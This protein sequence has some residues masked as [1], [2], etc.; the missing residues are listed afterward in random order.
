MSEKYNIK[1]TENKWRKKW[2]DAKAFDVCEDS[3]KPKYYVLAM[4]PYPSG[5]IH[6]GHVRNYTLSD[7]VARYKKSRGFNVLNPMGWDALGLPAENAAMERNVHPSDWTYSNIAQMKAQLLSM[8]LAID[9][10]REVATC[11]PE[12]YKHEQKM[13]IEFFK[14]G[15]AYRKDSLVNWDP[16]EN[17]VLANE[18]VVDGKGWRSGAPVERRKLYQ[19]FFK[20]TQYADNLLDG[21]KTLERWPDKVRIMQENWIGKSQGAQFKFDL[22]TPLHCHPEHREGSQDSSASPQ[23]DKNVSIEVYTTRPDTLFGASFVG[24]AADHPMAKTL[25]GD[26]PGFDEFLKKCSAGGTSEAAIE[27]A[28]KIGFDTGHRVAH[29]FIA[30][31]ELPVYLANFILM[32]YGTGAIFGCPAHDD[33]DFEF[34]TK[35]NLN[36]IPVISPLDADASLPPQAGGYRGELPYTGDGV[37]INSEWLNGKDV[38]SAKAAAIAKLEQL[39]IG[40]GVTKF[41]L[42]DWGVS[43]QRYWG[44][45]IPLIHCDACGIVPVPDDQLPVELPKDINYDEPTNPLVR[46]PTWKHTNCPKCGKPAIRE[47]DTCDTFFESSWYF[48]RYMDARNDKEAFSKQAASYWGAVDQYIGGVE[49][50]VLHLLYSR[51]FTR[52]LRDCGYPISHDE[53]FTGLFTQGMVTHATFQDE[54]GKY[55]FP[56]DVEQGHNGGW[57]KKDNG[58]PVTMGPQIKMSKSKKNVIDPQDIIDTYGADAARLF[59]LSDSPPERDIEWTTSGIE[60]AWRYINKLH[61]LISD[62]ASNLPPLTSSPQAGG[63]E[64]GSESALSLRRETHKTIDGVAKDIEAF[65]MNKAVARLREL[66]NTISSFTVRDDGDAWALREAIESFIIMI[67][68]MM[69]HL[70]EELWENLGHKTNLTQTPWPVA[71]QSL[72][73]NDTV[74]LAVQVNGKMRATIT[75]PIDAN[76][77]ETEN[78]ALAETNV[79]SAIAGKAIKKIIVVPGRIVNVVAA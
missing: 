5:R 60:G 9:W 4:L 45:P 67:N 42:R 59:I 11:R 54:D 64:G 2:N 27:Q 18:Q 73:Q 38:E 8:G 63:K 39:G 56:V 65:H 41:R 76:E 17:T 77:K 28:E 43:R 20:I 51:F 21:L 3:S 29:P 40:K 12:Y 10:S 6:I 34:A 47:T 49:H 55:L 50:A 36:I 61:R 57:I 22:T 30:G 72:L 25:A 35:Y 52:A 68:P 46:H 7:V 32:D 16:V 14:K 66:S 37:I 1:D 70:A 15:L 31:K 58:A 33:R 44:C 74:T 19:W 78:A 53:P 26:K 24:L 13:F 23:N 75:M 79:K 71:D 69:P 48:L 62:V